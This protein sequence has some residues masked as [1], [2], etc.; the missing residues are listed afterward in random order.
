[1]GIVGERD[2]VRRD[3]LPR[4][5]WVLRMGLVTG[6]VIS[7]AAC[8]ISHRPSSG[9]SPCTTAGHM[10]ARK[11]QSALAHL[12]PETKTQLA[13]DCDSSALQWV[14]V[15]LGG[16]EPVKALFFRRF[17]CNEPSDPD[18]P[19]SFDCTIAE[20]AVRVFVG[21]LGARTAE[22]QPVHVL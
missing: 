16:H 10:Q 3:V 13:R 21:D 18:D 15:G 20:I 14:I 1:M 6:L 7:G 2:A 22:V 8:S 12:A 17:D 19:L 4:T 5:T 9:S 11:L